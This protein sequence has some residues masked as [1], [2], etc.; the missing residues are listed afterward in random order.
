M[1]SSTSLD[2][3]LLTPSPSFDQLCNPSRQPAPKEVPYQSFQALSIPPAGNSEIQEYL[4][5][6]PH[7][8]PREPP[9]FASRWWRTHL[10]PGTADAFHK[11]TPNEH[12]IHLCKWTINW[13]SRLAMTCYLRATSGLFPGTV[14]AGFRPAPGRREVAQRPVRSVCR[15]SLQRRERIFSLGLLLLTT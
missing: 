6:K 3:D 8:H 7:S 10:S 4:A 5:E 14:L 2:L 9:N 11:P 13:G 15:S 1:K 12:M